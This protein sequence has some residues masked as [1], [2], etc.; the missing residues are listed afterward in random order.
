MIDFNQQGL[1]SEYVNLHNSTNESAWQNI[2]I[3]I[4]CL[5]GKPGPTTLVLGGVHGDEYEGPIAIE[6]IITSI[7]LDKLNGRLILLP[8]TNVTAVMSGTRLTPEDGLNLNRVFPGNA[9]GSL[10]QRIANIITQ[11]L[12]PLADH[13]IDL[14]SGGKT[15]NFAPCVFIYEN[16]GE[17]FQTTLNA[18]TAFGAHFTVFIED[19][20]SEVMIDDVVKKAGKV[21]IASELG[22]AGMLTRDSAS[23]ATNGLKRCLSAL[24]HIKS[25]TTPPETKFARLSEHSEHIIC[26]D[27]CVFEPSVNLGDLLSKGDI[28]GYQH[29]LDRIDE[30]PKPIISKTTGALLCLCGQALVKRGDVIAIVVEIFDSEKLQ[31]S[32]I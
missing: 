26:D 11:D 7:D 1:T 8:A 9:N 23:L 6:N 28:I 30:P 17:N 10:T 5:N 14:H 19:D 2:R 21:M 27:T 15:L 31:K 13:V 29:R 3:P 24:G 4:Y 20:F 22:G 25:I 18:A 16:T 12:I 32:G